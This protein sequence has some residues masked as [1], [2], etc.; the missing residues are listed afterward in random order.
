MPCLTKGWKRQC[1]Y[2]EKGFTRTAGKAFLIGGGVPFTPAKTQKA[3][4]SKTYC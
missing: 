1:A 3:C 2:F 4:R